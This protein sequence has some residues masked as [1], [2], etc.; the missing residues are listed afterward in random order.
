M[1]RILWQS[2]SR[3]AVASAVQHLYEPWTAAVRG[4][5]GKAGPVA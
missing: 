3:N 4:L 2:I 1:P 5:G